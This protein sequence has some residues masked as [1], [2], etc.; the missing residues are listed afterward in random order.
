MQGSLQ[1]GWGFA[2]G[3][4]HSRPRAQPGQRPRDWKVL[5]VWNDLGAQQ[6]LRKWL[7]DKSGGREARWVPTVVTQTGSHRDMN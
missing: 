4:D 2:W 3:G 5:S 6:S 1:D 7:E